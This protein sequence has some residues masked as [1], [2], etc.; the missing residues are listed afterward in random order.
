MKVAFKAFFFLRVEQMARKS[1]LHTACDFASDAHRVVAGVKPC[2]STWHA[3]G[4][5]GLCV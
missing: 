1:Q 3:A 2:D 5:E 4:P